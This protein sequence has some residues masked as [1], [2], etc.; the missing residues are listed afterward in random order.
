MGNI[1][2]LNAFVILSLAIYV[3]KTQE[4]TIYL[5][6][7]CIWVYFITLLHILP[8]FGY[9]KLFYFYF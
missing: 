1:Q 8:L 4:I 5:K 3:L 2:N 7:C 6:L 9:H